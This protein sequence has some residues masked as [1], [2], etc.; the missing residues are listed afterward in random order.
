MKD[1]GRAKQMALA[2][3]RRE[4][5]KMQQTMHIEAAREQRAKGDD[6]IVEARNT[7]E[8]LHTHMMN[9]RL[10][11]Q[12]DAALTEFVDVLNRVKEELPLDREGKPSLSPL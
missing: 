2:T 5:V 11:K 12:T 1:Q 7:T 3:R 9:C 8:T 10:L 6:I 4:D